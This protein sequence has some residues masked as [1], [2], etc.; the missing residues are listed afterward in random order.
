VY[1]LLILAYSQFY[2]ELGVRPSEVGL[3]YGPGIGG[4]AGVAIVLLVGSAT[5]W[6][7]YAAFELVMAAVRRPR[8]AAP[9]AQPSRRGGRAKLREL[10]DLWPDHLRDRRAIAGR[11]ITIILAVSLVFGF[12][13]LI[14]A[15]RQADT[16][17]EGGVIE[18]WRFLFGVE[19]LA[20][21]AD[22]ATVQTI[23][24]GSTDSQP[25]L[26]RLPADDLFYLGRSDGM[27]V[28]YEAGQRGEQHVWHLPASGVSVRASNCETKHSATDPLCN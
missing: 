1:G 3:Q 27:V 22:P 23:S 18:P 5:T 14:V 15:D 10:A 12:Y 9:D 26:M 20:V 28:M 11:V 13:M 24:R 17:K 21:R 16:V 4:I 19:V 7:L 25:P 6:I 2:T 8:G